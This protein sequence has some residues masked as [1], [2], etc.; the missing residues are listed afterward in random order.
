[1]VLY[2]WNALYVKRLEESVKVDRRSAFVILCA[3]RLS[4]TN[5]SLVPADK[6]CLRPIGHLWQPALHQPYIADGF[7]MLDP[8]ISPGAYESGALLYSTYT[9]APPNLRL[10]QLRFLVGGNPRLFSEIMDRAVLGWLP[11]LEDWETM[12]NTRQWVEAAPATL[13]THGISPLG[14]QQI[15]WVGKRC[16]KTA[17]PRRQGIVRLDASD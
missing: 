17:K 9:W 6:M 12:Q 15:S 3:C 8:N 1:M 2:S 13:R 10:L 14:R 4:D 16:E 11:R 7:L 5:D